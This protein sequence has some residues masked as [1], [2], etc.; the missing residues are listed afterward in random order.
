MNCHEDALSNVMADIGSSLNVLPKFIISKLAYQG[1]P[2]RFSGVVL[3]AF[4]GSRKTIIGEVD[5]P[6]KIGP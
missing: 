5:L 2:M 4:D 3:K 6:M 1:A